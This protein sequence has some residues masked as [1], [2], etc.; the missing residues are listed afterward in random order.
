MIISFG[1]SGAELSEW[2]VFRAH[3]PSIS[4]PQRS[5]VSGWAEL[6]MVVRYVAGSSRGAWRS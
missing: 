6:N 3:R 1:T 4:R 2:N 5:V